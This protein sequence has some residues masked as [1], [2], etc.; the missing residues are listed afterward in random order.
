MERKIGDVFTFDGK[1]LEVIEGDCDD[2]YFRNLNCLSSECV[3][4]GKCT[5]R[6][7]DKTIY[8]KL[9]IK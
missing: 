8:F 4:L 6:N 9:I 1:Q 5:F 2:C 7:D 3:D